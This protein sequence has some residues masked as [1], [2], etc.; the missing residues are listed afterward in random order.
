MLRSAC[1]VYAS[2]SVQQQCEHLR[3]SF[4]AAC[5][6]LHVKCMQVSVYMYASVC[7]CSVSVCKC[8]CVCSVSVC[9]GVCVYPTFVDAI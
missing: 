1:K 7:V 3:T 2:V 6:A 8:V 4:Y 9:Q 5:S